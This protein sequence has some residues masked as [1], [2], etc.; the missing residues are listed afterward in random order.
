[1]S[2][3]ILHEK[4]RYLITAFVCIFGSSLL[5]LNENNPN[6]S[7]IKLNDN[8]LSGLFFII[9]HLLVSG[10]FNFGTKKTNQR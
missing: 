4:F 5:L 6:V 10:F 2:L 7:K 9:C 1:M 3:L 8:K